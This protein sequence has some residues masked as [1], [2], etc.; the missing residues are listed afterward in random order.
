MEASDYFAAF[1]LIFTA[2]S[3][4]ITR[5][6]LQHAKD[7]QKSS[8]KNLIEYEKTEILRQI[9]ENKSILNKSRIEIGALQE[10]FNIEPQ[11]VKELMKNF[12]SIFTESMP[13]IEYAISCLETDHE[14]FNNWHGN[15]NYTDIMRA[16]AAFH[17][18]LKQF[19]IS[20]EQTIKCIA[21]F[22]EKLKEAKNYVN[23]AT[24]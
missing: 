15:L 12:T 3:F 17:E 19:E 2:G 22:E 16:K 18:E 11:P 13:S 6:A 1:A 9:S 8:E 5:K 7:T 14:K 24:R 10:N 4:W 23:G 21:I 20:H